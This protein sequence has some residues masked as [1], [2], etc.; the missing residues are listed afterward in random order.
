MKSEHEHNE[1]QLTKPHE[2]TRVSQR[3]SNQ[4]T[5]FPFL[6]IAAMDSDFLTGLSFRH[7][8]ICSDEANMSGSTVG[9]APRVVWELPAVSS[10]ILAD[11]GRILPETWLCSFV[12]GL[13]NV[14][15]MKVKVLMVWN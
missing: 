2:L 5:H 13:V 15:V 3:D 14:N 11:F 1:L 7:A 8:A 12:G 6:G 9:L 4:L 10:R